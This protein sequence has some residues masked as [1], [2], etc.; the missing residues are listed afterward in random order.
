MWDNRTWNWCISLGCLHFEP[1]ICHLRP[2]NITIP[3]ISF[4][5]PF[6]IRLISDEQVRTWRLSWWACSQ[7]RSLSKFVRSILPASHHALK[8]GFKSWEYSESL[9]RFLNPRSQADNMCNSMQTQIFPRITPSVGLPILYLNHCMKWPVTF[10]QSFSFCVQIP[11]IS[12]LLHAAS[13]FAKCTDSIHSRRLAGFS[14]CRYPSVAFNHKTLGRR[15]TKKHC[16]RQ[17]LCV[18]SL[19]LQS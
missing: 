16:S 18:V 6:V 3:W 1:M 14:R 11:S 2:L 4:F 10:P 17:C 13:N 19:T 7:V 8:I 5:F 15:G 12:D 9:L